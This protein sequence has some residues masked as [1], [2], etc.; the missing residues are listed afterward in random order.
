MAIGEK[1]Y[2]TQLFRQILGC[3]WHKHCRHKDKIKRFL[4]MVFFVVNI[5]K[6]TASSAEANKNKFFPA[7]FLP[8][9][10]LL[11]FLQSCSSSIKVSWR[12]CI[13]EKAPRSSPCCCRRW[14]HSCEWRSPAW[15][16]LSMIG[17]SP[18]FQALSLVKINSWFWLI[19]PR[20]GIGLMLNLS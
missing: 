15:M 8:F 12:W 11:L 19:I 6:E 16:L 13:V 20:L 17:Q 4:K 3:S 1:K 18:L 2:K 14:S 10:F 5:N 7:V 9:V